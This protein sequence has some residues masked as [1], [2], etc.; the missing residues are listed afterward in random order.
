MKLYKVLRY[1]LVLSLILTSSGGWF[2]KDVFAAAPQVRITEIMYDPIGN[3]DKE[4]IEIFNG[5]DTIVNLSG[6]SFANGVDYSFPSGTTLDSGKYGVIVRNI[7]VF[8]AAYPSARVF[9][10]YVGKLLGSGELIK[11]VDKNGA[12]VTQV[13]YRSGGGWP[14][15]AR[16][17]GPSL[18]LIKT[19]GDETSSSC[20]GSSTVM[21]GS[22]G[23]ANSTS[24]GGSCANKAY[25]TTP[26]PAPAPTQPQSNPAQSNNGNGGQQNQNKPTEQ[27]GTPGQEPT[28]ETGDQSIKDLSVEELAVLEAEGKLE[29][30]ED[31]GDVTKLGATDPAIKK[32]AGLV[33]GFFIITLGAGYVL[34]GKLAKHS[35]KH[36]SSLSSKLE[37]QISRLNFKKIRI[38]K[39]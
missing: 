30:Q 15:N 23:F 17:G 27:N 22:P 3:G 7:N 35:K 14:S 20:W 9:G 28:P 11:L 24:G 26:A 25:L 21:G 34:Y 29:D 39:K 1:V 33:L 16:N 4:F 10:Q 2:T 19:S 37:K 31:E 36:P 13:D 18:S 38:I 5:S 8:R 32:I 12:A 6:W